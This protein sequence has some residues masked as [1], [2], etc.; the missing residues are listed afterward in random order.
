MVKKG[1]IKNRLFNDLAHDFAKKEC[2]I[3]SSMSHPNIVKLYDYSDTPEE[4][5][6]FMEY[7]DKG[8]YLCKKIIEVS[9]SIVN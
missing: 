9:K 3:H 7:A 6:L 8:D 2:S 1:I 5:Q 4:Y